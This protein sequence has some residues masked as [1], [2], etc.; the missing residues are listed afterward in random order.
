[1]GL[2]EHAPLPDPSPARARAFLKIQDGCDESC[3]YCVVPRVRPRLRS[4]P[5][6]AVAARLRS[7]AAAGVPEIVLCGV[8]LGRY[9]ARD[10]AGMQTPLAGL[11]ERLLEIPGRF[12]LRLSSLEIGEADDRLADLVAGFR[13]RL[14]PHLHLPLQ[15]G[16]DAVLRRMRR[17]YCAAAFAARVEALRRRIPDLALFTDIITGFP[18]ETAAESR[19]S[20]DFARRLGLCGLHIFRYSPRP[21]TVA[22]A[23]PDQVR[24]AAVRER[25]QSWQGLDRSLRQ[26]HARRTVGRCRVAAPLKTKAQALTEDFLTVRLDRRLVPGLWRV[27]VTGASGGK[28]QARV[29]GPWMGQET[30]W[31]PDGASGPRGGPGGFAPPTAWP[32]D[33]AS[34]PRGGRTVSRRQRA[35]RNFLAGSGKYRYNLQLH[36]FPW[37]NVYSAK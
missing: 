6:E 24:A 27:L 7:L 20:L 29:L 3:S 1:M 26:G 33:G 14:C 11:L 21:G 17:P 34:G 13:G 30:A 28:A 19:E 22:A 25:L 10:A 36:G 32:P 12:R 4:V 5:P 15:S 37:L 23:M 2:R 18:G 35:A 16:S 8:R 31:P 9:Y